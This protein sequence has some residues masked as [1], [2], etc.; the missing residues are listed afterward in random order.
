MNNGFGIIKYDKESS[1]VT[2]NDTIQK[3]WNMESIEIKIDDFF[4]IIEKNTFVSDVKIFQDF[5]EKNNSDNYIYVNIFSFVSK[6]FTNVVVSYCHDDFRIYFTNTNRYDTSFISN[7]SHEL[8]TPLNGILGMVTFLNETSLDSEQK[9]DVE[10]IQQCSISLLSIINDVLD[11]SKLEVNKIILEKKPFDL[12]ECINDISDDILSKIEDV[13]F[14]F[15]ISD[16]I[17]LHLI[18]DS[19]RLQQILKNILYNSVKFTEKGTILLKVSCIS[20]TIFNELIKS[21]DTSQY[22][23]EQD[24]Q[25]LKFDI[26]DTGCGISPDDTDKIFSPFIQCQTTNISSNNSIGQGTGLGLSIC[27]K[28]VSLMKGS[29]WLDSSTVNGGSHFVFIIKTNIDKNFV[30]VNRIFNNEGIN[31]KKVVLV[32]SDVESRIELAKLCKDMN[33]YLTVYSNVNEALAMIK[34]EQNL[35]FDICL[36]NII[37]DDSYLFA[38]NIRRDLSVLN[39]DVPLVGIA[40]NDFKKRD[41]TNF[42]FILTK[43]ITF[44]KLQEIFIN[45]FDNMSLNNQIKSIS[46]S[47]PII[48]PSPV[49][50]TENPFNPKKVIRILIAEDVDTNRRILASFLK[51]FGYI[52]VTQ[53]RDGL[54]CI[55]ELSRNEYDVLL[56]DIK[57]PRFNGD[58]VARMVTNFYKVPPQK[59]TYHFVNRKKPVIIAVTAYSSNEDRDAYKRLGF[60]NVIAKPLNKNELRQTLEKIE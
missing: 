12:Q 30:H 8:R 35:K 18:G 21:H 4:K 60:S 7:I 24:I 25:Y 43:P 33:L 16:N 57:M 9:E 26:I 5:I 3:L 59:S 2:V 13:H 22:I 46:Y 56:L 20:E 52:N 10:L 42:K 1:I 17:N 11:F 32:D 27:K 54:E 28:L 48:P 44:N 23:F 40:Q 58:E 29:I 39:W 53:T 45:I 49:I 14:K 41:Y 36:V 15:N 34:Y 55:E 37:D 50:V 38:N 51:S 6:S 47:R 19:N 31:K